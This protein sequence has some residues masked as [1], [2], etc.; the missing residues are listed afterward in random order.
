MKEKY[1]M[2]LKK[3]MLKIDVTESH[4]DEESNYSFKISKR[5]EIID[6]IAESESQVFTNSVSFKPIIEP[7]K[8]RF[9][10]LDNNSEREINL[11]AENKKGGGIKDKKSRKSSMM[12]I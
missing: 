5:S 11:K 8:P 4:D 10:D 2:D 9:I 7:L 6:S 12:G 1:L 3:P